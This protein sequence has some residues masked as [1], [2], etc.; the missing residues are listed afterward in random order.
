MTDKKEHNELD[1]DKT[2]AAT[3]HKVEN[4]Y[5]NNKK[6][7]NYAIV[8]VLAILALYVGFTKFYLS[9]LETEAQR[10]SFA[11]QR[12]FDMDSFN[13]ALNG[14]DQI[15]G[16]ETISDE[17]GLTKMGN[18]AHYYAGICNL[19]LGNFEAAIDH[20]ESFSTGNK[21]VGPLAEGA[22]GDA[23]VE[24]GDLDKGV[25]H[26]IAAAKMS[27]NKLT[28]PVFYKKAGQVYEEQKEYG[29]ALDM[30]E[31]IKKDFADAQEAQDIDKYIA[32]AKA[33]ESAE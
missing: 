3:T 25:K 21:L 11:A 23:Y 16:F 18:L 33:M 29:R 20:L 4:F 22:L 27:K 13:L 10:E 14:N 31:T 7:I 30:Y 26:Y 19:R 8:G 12:Y 32:R 2:L 17:Y 5:H 6:Q 24:T 9:P 1:L 15:T 28:A